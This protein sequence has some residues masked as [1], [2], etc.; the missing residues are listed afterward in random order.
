VR[1]QVFDNAECSGEAGLDI[2]LSGDCAAIS[3]GIW[4]KMN[5]DTCAAKMCF[6]SQC[7]NCTVESSHNEC[8]EAE[9]MSLLYTFD[10]P[11]QTVTPGRTTTGRTTSGRPRPV[12]SGSTLQ[13][14]LVVVLVA[15]LT[16][17]LAL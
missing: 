8:Y 4:L 14:T 3:T 11:C 6:D 2:T 13:M 7:S 12:S 10:P 5:C 16:V 17:I 1:Q 15:I 9:S